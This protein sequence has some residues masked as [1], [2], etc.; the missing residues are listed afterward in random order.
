MCCENQVASASHWLCIGQHERSSPSTVT[1]YNIIVKLCLQRHARSVAAKAKAAASSSGAGA[2]S[3]K[4]PAPA[5]AAESSN[6]GVT[7]NDSNDLRS[8]I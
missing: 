7:P 6:S 3:S 5:P 8:H 2:A 1:L 4:Q